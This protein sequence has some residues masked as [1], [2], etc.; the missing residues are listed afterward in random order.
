MSRSC[1]VA[2]RYRLRELQ[3]AMPIVEKRMSENADLFGFEVGPGMVAK[4]MRVNMPLRQLGVNR[5]EQLMSIGERLDCDK[6]PQQHGS[7]P[8]ER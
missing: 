6:I 7:A 2:E 1:Q 8:Q 4:I 3:I 5:L